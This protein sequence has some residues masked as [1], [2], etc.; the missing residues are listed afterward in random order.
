MRISYL[1]FT[2]LALLTCVQGQSEARE[3]RREGPPTAG[4]G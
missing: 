1:F 3:H 4:D 2:L